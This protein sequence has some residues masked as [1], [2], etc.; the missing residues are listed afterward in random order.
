MSLRN[1][2]SVGRRSTTACTEAKKCSD[3]QAN[4]MFT[5]PDR[6]AVQ[7]WRA[8]SESGGAGLVVTPAA[9]PP[10]VASQGGVMSALIKS[11]Q[12]KK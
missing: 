8:A 1:G 6:V 12:K 4:G 2:H 3:V 10:T 5:D 7:Q 11:W 9:L